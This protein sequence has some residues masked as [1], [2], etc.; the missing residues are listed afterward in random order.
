MKKQTHPFGSF[1]VRLAVSGL[2][3]MVLAG[4]ESAKYIDNERKRE[5]Y[6]QMLG[7]GVI[8]DLRNLQVM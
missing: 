8:L 7:N 2:A 1:I 5:I 4:N 6:L 3:Q